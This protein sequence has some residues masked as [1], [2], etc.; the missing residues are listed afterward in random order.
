MVLRFL[1]EKPMAVGTGCHTDM[2]RR[3]LAGLSLDRYLPIVVGADQVA[4]PKPAGDTFLLAAEK[5]GIAPER[6]LVFE[7]ADAGLKAAAAAGMAAID[8]RNLWPV[9][10]PLQ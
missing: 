1:G 10:R 2:A 4:N 8:V 5:L 7:D 3:I 6:C 9:Q